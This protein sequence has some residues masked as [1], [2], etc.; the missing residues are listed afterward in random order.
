MTKYEIRLVLL[1]WFLS[2]ITANSQ[3]QDSLEIK[4]QASA[5]ILLRNSNGLPFYAGG[6]YIPQVNYN[7][8]FKNN[9][10]IDFEASV[11]IN[12]NTGINFSDS[13]YSYGEIKPY[14]LWAR[15][16]S[17]QFEL[18][19][20]LQKIN[21]GSASIMRPL[22]WFDQVDPRDPLKLTDGVWSV[23]VRYYFLDNANIWLW[24]LYGNK[25]PKG[26]ETLR[27]NIRFPEAG[28]RIQ[29]PVPHGE[30][31]FSYHH[32]VADSENQGELMPHFQNIKENRIGFDMKLDLVVGCWFEGSWTTNDKDLGLYTNQEILNAGI[33]YTF[34]LGNGLYTAYE[35]LLASGDRSAFRFENPLSFSLLSVSYPIGISDKISGIVYYD[36][37]N[38]NIYNFLSW[39]R[40][41]KSITLYIMGYW[42]PENYRIPAL[43]SSRNL[44]S[45]KGIQFM[46]VFN[47]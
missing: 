32:R 28:G 1:L 13:L 23:L 33:D 6:R 45:G 36:W 41:F 39:N 34:T 5:W 46:F 19:L 8:Q 15:Y 25:D 21:F 3:V 22:M 31:A 14:R 20:G 11:N 47:H 18:R 24:G 29:F 7:M 16:S 17:R 12:G 27:T 37:N 44:F 30:A 4:G 35:Q 2:A 38:K 26:W 43:N 9:K 10:K 40:Q 42:N